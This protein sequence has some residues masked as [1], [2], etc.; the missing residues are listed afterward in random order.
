MSAVSLSLSGQP[1][2]VSRMPMRATP[3]DPTDTERTMPSS[4]IGRRIS[5][6]CTEARAARTASSSVVAGA[7]IPV[8]LLLAT[9]CGLVQGIVVVAVGGAGRVVGLSGRLLDVLADLLALDL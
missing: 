8:M 4:V 1:A 6:S 2:T 9:G 3:S 7:D 5:G